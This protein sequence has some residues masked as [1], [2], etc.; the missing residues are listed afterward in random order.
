MEQNPVKPMTTVQLSGKRSDRRALLP[1]TQQGGLTKRILSICLAT[2]MLLALVTTSQPSS[3]KAD[4]FPTGPATHMVSA[5]PGSMNGYGSDCVYNIYSKGGE[6]LNYLFQSYARAEGNFTARLTAPDGTQIS[7][8]TINASTLAASLSGSTPLTQEGVYS[9]DFTPPA[10]NISTGVLFD[11]TVVGSNGIAI[12]GR[13]W[14]VNFSNAATA[15][16]PDFSLYCV[17]NAGYIY[18]V[19]IKGFNG[20]NS[21]FRFD[22]IGLVGPD[23]QTPLNHSVNGYGPFASGAQPYRIFFAP[24]A[25]DLPQTATV[26]GVPNSYVL[27]PLKDASIQLLRFDNYPTDKIRRAGD[28][29]ANFN[30]E[31]SGPIT[32]EVDVNN[33][34]SYTDAVDRSYQYSVNGDDPSTPANENS[35]VEIPFDGLD[36]NGGSI[37]L[38]QSINAR[39]VVDKMSPFYLTLYDPE[40]LGGITITQMN[41]A[42]AGND[43]IYW[44]QSQILPRVGGGPLPGTW[45]GI[46]TPPWGFN[47]PLVNLDGIS[48]AGG[49]MG[50]GD[51]TTAGDAFGDGSTIEAWI[52]Q[53]SDTTASMSLRT[54]TVPPDN[55]IAKDDKNITSQ[56]SP[57]SG[58][59]L[60]NDTGPGITVIDHTAPA[61][62][63]VV[64]NPD[65]TYTYTPKPGFNGTD[66]FTYTIKDNDYGYTSTATVLIL[67]DPL[68]NAVNDANNTSI[69]TPVSGTALANDSGV[70][71]SVT[72]HTNPANGTVVIN[73]DGT[74]TYT[75]NNGFAGTDS[76][77][78]TITDTHGKT[79]T[80]TV[81]VRVDALPVAVN[82]TATTALGTPKTGN[83][84]TNDTGNG[85][86]VTNNT[87]PLHG[88]V[89]VNPDG[90]Y[91]Y[92]PGPVYTG[93]DSF[94]YTI[95]DSHGKTSTATVNLTVDPLPLAVDDS[96]HTALG[97][98][99][100]GRALANDSGV[101]IVVTSNSAPANGTVSIDAAGNYSYTPR[102]GFAGTD[103]FTYTITDRNGKTDT[104]TVT[105]TVDPLPD[106]VNDTATTA[107]GDPVTGKVLANDTGVGI[108][109]TSNTQPVH[110]TVTVAPDG[111]YTYTPAS[112]FSGADTFTYTVT[113]RNGKT[114]TATVSVTVDPLPVAAPDT[115]Y[116]AMGTS[117]SG[118]VLSN[119]SGVGIRVSSN[120]PV[121][122]GSVIVNPDGS[123]LYAPEPGYVGPDSFSYTVTDVHG[124]TSTTT[125]SLMVDP[126]PV[127]K[128]DSTFTSTTDPVSGNVLPNDTGVGISVTSHTD[129]AHGTVTIAPDGSYTYT[130]DPGFTGPDSFTY[131]VTDRDGKTST[132]TVAVTVDPL[133][134]AVDDT[135][136]GKVGQT[137]TGAAL[138]NDVGAGLRVTSNTPPAHGVV[139][140]NPDGTFIYLPAA[141]FKGDDSFT[142]TVTDRDGKTSTAT[143]T[144]SLRDDSSDPKPGEETIGANNFSYGVDEDRLTPDAA[145]ILS[146]V[147]AVDKEGNPI[148][149][150]ALRVD[151]AELAAINAMI[152]SDTPGVM[153]LTFTTPEG[154]PVTVQV[155]LESHGNGDP[156][157]TDRITGDDFKYGIDEGP[158]TKPDAKIFAGVK[159]FDKDGNPIDLS[160]VSVDTTELAAINAK[161][162]AKDTST[163]MPLTFTT[164]D[165]TPITVQVT[166]ADHGT[167]EAGKTD[168][169]VG[170]NYS[171]PGLGRPITPEA[172]K[173]LASVVAKDKDGN[174]IDLSKVSV[175]TTELAAL[176]KAVADNKEG[177]F[178][179]TFTSPDGTKVTVT[180]H[181]THT[182]TPPVIDVK[183]PALY[184][185][186]GVTL[187]PDQILKLA[188]VSIS[189]LE[190][191][192]IPNSDLVVG[193]YSAIKWSVVNYPNGDG[194]VITLD[195]E[196]SDGL[197]AAQ[198]QIAVFVEPA[199]AKI[200]DKNPDP[201]YPI[202]EL[203]DGTKV[204]TDEDGNPIIWKPVAAKLTTPVATPKTPASGMPKTGDV[205]SVTTPLLLAAAALFFVLLA[206]RR[207]QTGQAGRA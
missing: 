9:L 153:P 73:P 111:S 202:K 145:K 134:D 8:G 88:T 11:L 63:T 180:V 21:N 159:A 171:Y 46:T 41:G 81:T 165:G 150:S 143:V 157:V 58:T 188:G 23:G 132:A 101:G 206:Y 190:D 161:I 44:D 160:K 98:V 78:Y 156:G 148:P 196:D 67:V 128:D 62:G 53:G 113:D 10:R 199:N 175:D 108:S 15:I 174:P 124:K 187:T 155:T 54:V 12:P 121:S 47:G 82:D 152:D 185:Q 198:R 1:K 203:P 142:Y 183:R 146:Q 176:N 118:N 69:N 75:P 6:T 181:V 154:T 110:G 167:G 97:T 194:Y 76:F 193:G 147:T 115:A 126:L 166:L 48:S 79:S 22:S 84:I 86:T 197:P 144:L 60:D 27:P 36:G 26:N 105:V 37:P 138:T 139:A 35:G 56:N 114:D 120:T 4:G 66:T 195:A 112:G 3:A 33:N 24:P 109:V 192:S 116:T 186:K 151:P 17:S 87:Q 95:T 119:D 178:P 43:I 130:A 70:G 99:V 201:N 59:T 173:E 32:V 163:P 65:G 83:V 177:D 169:I 20:F 103:S 85:I 39:I 127:A 123:Y 189:D 13:V 141:G 49:V 170:N 133:P 149:V 125:V 200:T 19:D 92:T 168:H 31:F 122:H 74:Y 57:V 104:A 204:G 172:A 136:I 28:F 100:S 131:T 25:A 191:G 45:N 51:A 18:K 71:I 94:T 158:L 80:A 64:I 5:D 117:K 182:N 164:P 140:I 162:A 205:L 137:I 29:I 96:T 30:P 52:F 68:P 7:L 38:T 55:T 102:A 107:Q 77:T 50:W 135:Y 34:G 89:V 14:T 93:P 90:T 61:N 207:R 16:V 2:A 106:A 40:I 42:D 129:P 179:L 72:G 91:T 184:V